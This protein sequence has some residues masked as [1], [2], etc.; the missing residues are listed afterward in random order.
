[1]SACAARIWPRR[2]PRETTACSSEPQ[3]TN[4]PP[5]PLMPEHKG[6]NAINDE[7]NKVITILCM[8]PRTHATTK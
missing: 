8:S 5:G 4:A 1:M 7:K 3:T 6:D 2:G